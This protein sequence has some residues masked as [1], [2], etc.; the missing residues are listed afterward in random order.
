MP[1]LRKTEAGKSLQV[2]RVVAD[3]AALTANLRLGQGNL[4]HMTS[5][6]LED[7][8]ELVNWFARF[9]QPF[10]IPFWDD[11][12]RISF[13]F[14]SQLRGRASCVFEEG[15]N[16]YEM[17]GNA[18]SIHYGPGRSGR[19]YQQGIAQ[20]LSVMVRPDVFAGWCAE[21]DPALNRLLDSGGYLEGHH[22]GELFATAQ[23]LSRALSPQMAARQHRARHPLWFRGQA[24]MLIGLILEARDSA[25]A[26]RQSAHES[27]RLYRVRDR[28]LADLSCA[29]NLMELAKEAGMS[30]PTLTRGFRKAFGT[31]LYGLFQQER[32][33][34]A[35]LRLLSEEVSV[36]RVAV[37]LGYTNVSHFGAAFRKQFGIPPSKLTRRR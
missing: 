6:V 18:A 27:Q 3:P 22:G 11:N 2:S 8:V 21:T 36:T 23:L 35:R 31:S 14:T 25:R 37:E 32:M 4:C 19:Y 24:L 28:L 16:E 13:S 30:V 29:P 5:L 20:N 26:R 34:V 17:Q 7:G 33:H 15:G 9:E 12:G 1:D 10:Q